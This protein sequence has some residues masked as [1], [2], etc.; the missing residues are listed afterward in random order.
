[1]SAAQLSLGRRFLGA[2]VVTS[3]GVAM[4]VAALSTIPA[5]AGIEV[6]A[7]VVLP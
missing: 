3:L 2:L 4:V 1:M 7:N 6:L 5:E